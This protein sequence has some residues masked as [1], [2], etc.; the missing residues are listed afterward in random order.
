[1]RERL[2]RIADLSG[3]TIQEFDGNK[4]YYSTGNINTDNYETITYKN[5]PSRANVQVIEKDILIAKM[6]NT[7]K[8]TIVTKEMEKNVYSTGFTVLTTRKLYYRYLYYLLCSPEFIEKK[9]VFSVGTTQIAINDETLMNIEVEYV[10]DYRIQKKIAEILDKKI[11]AIDNVIEKTKKNIKE[12]KNYKN[13]LIA[14]TVTKGIKKQRNMKESNVDWN[15]HIPKEW[16][17]INPKALF[18]QRKEKAH[19]EDRQLTASQK[20]GIMYQ[21]E[22]MDKEGVRVVIVQKDF[23]ILKHVE[24]NDFVIS[25][26]S[27][28]GGLEYSEISGCISSAYVMLIP[29]MKKV[30]PKFY[31]WFFKSI[32]YINA[33][34]STS[35]LIRDGQAMRYSNFCQIR[36]FDIPIEEQKEIADYLDK[37]I[38]EVDYLI[39]KNEDMNK[40]LEQY[41]KSLIYEYVTGKK[42]V[43]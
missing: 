15:S 7:N 11:T 43:V 20:N 28:Q 8:T 23:D 17:E 25:M 16:N 34:Q 10:Q 27:F 19:I 3:K 2:K 26:R 9:D 39:E 36:L 5:K 40:E 37:R 33:L 13:S 12:Y 32:K 38:K 35:N 29:N 31:K 22:Y 41:K 18:F 4:K 1:M 21:D 14:E 30:Y 6:K 42:E 24:P